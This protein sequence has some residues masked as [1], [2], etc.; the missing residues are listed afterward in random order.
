MT[1]FLLIV[2]SAVVGCSVTQ[3]RSR[4]TKWLDDYIN[5]CVVLISMVMIL[6]ED[7]RR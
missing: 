1:R 3:A 4:L 2:L 7:K 5:R 6:Q